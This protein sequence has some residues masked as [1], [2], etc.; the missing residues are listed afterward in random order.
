[1]SAAVR[2]AVMFDDTFTPD[3][4]PMPHGIDD[5]RRGTHGMMLFIAGE[6][7][8]FVMLFWVYFYLG[9]DASPANWETPAPRLFYPLVM[10]VVL[11]ASS[12]AAH[13]AEMHVDRGDTRMARAAVLITIVLGLAFLWLQKLEY[14]ERLTEIT[15]K[16]NAYGSIFYTLTGLHGAHVALGVLMLAYVV[17]LPR[18]GKTDR[19]PYRPLHNAAMYWHFVDVVWVFIVVVVYVLPHLKR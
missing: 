19:P 7:M 3:A 15:P 10:L 5:E 16:T 1:M 8:L 6:A 12:V 13:W 9:H 17:A 11:L 14:A 18:I 2:R 4:E